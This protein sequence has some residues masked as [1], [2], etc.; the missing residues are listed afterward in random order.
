MRSNLFNEYL[1]SIIAQGLSKKKK[2]EI[3]TE[4][5]NHLQDKTDWYIEIGYGE[6]EATQ[7]AV[8]EMGESAEVRDKLYKILADCE[9]TRKKQGTK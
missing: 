2:A 4:F 9:M 5:E 6:D 3:R 1:D 8:A 7:K